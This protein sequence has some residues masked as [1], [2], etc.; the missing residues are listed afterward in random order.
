MG[1]SIITPS[2]GSASCPPGE[3]P[4]G[5]ARYRAALILR[6]A[7]RFMTLRE[8][9]EVLGL[10]LSAVSRYSNLRLLP[11]VES[12]LRIIEGVLS[13]Q[14]LSSILMKR[15]T[16]SRAGREAT[17]YDITSA[18]GDPDVL[19]LVGEYVCMRSRGLF[20]AIVAP[21]VGGVTFATAVAMVSRKPLAIA[22]RIRMGWERF[23]EIPVYRD[24]ATVDYYY[25]NLDYLE[26]VSTAIIVDDFGV[27]GATISGFVE[28]LESHGIEVKGVY[29]MVGVGGDW[30][31]A[32]PRAEAILEIG[33]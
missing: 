7:R 31:R 33:L 17:V 8:L 28:A 26:G 14:V 13:K 12:A 25:L 16:A 9:S 11:S 15:I 32:H 30:R 29:L 21:E 20:D 1:C 10:P 24:P 22:R 18:A 19:H 5:E 2:R 27:K 23:A 4:H 6:S 3:A